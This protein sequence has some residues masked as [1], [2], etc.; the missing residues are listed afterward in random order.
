MKPVLALPIAV[1]MLC[2]SMPSSAVEMPVQKPGLW[3]MTMSSSAMPG[4]ARSYTM[5]LD[6]AFIA[7]GKASADAHMKDCS[8]H[9]IRKEGNAWTADMECTTS[10]MHSVTHSVTTVHGDD[11]FHSQITSTM[12]KKTTVMTVDNQWLGACKPGQKV[13]VPTQ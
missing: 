9:D 4:G 12:G 10:G 8:K 7:A 6:A 13:G 3:K 1:L 5:C 2:A 11:S